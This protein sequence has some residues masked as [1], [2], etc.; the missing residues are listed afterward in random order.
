MALVGVVEEV[1]VDELLDLER[2]RRHILDDLREEVRD[3]DA[4]RDE[5]EEALEGVDLVGVEAGVEELGDGGVVGVVVE[6]RVGAHPPHHPRGRRA[7]R[8]KSEHPV[9][10]GRAGPGP[11]L[12]RSGFRRRWLVSKKWP[13]SLGGSGSGAVDLDLA[14]VG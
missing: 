8:L 1:E 4:L 13:E 12:W 5:G 2:L 10:A 6:M 7:A 11:V 14:A 3:V 9:P